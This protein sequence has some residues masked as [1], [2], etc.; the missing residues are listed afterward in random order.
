MEGQ[1]YRLREGLSVRDALHMKSLVGA[2]RHSLGHVAAQ[3]RPR[4][5]APT[6]TS[7]SLL[8]DLNRSRSVSTSSSSSG[9]AITTSRTSLGSPECDAAPA[10]TTTAPTVI[11]LAVSD[12]PVSEGSLPARQS[13]RTSAPS[14][15]VTPQ[16][17]QQI[18]LFLQH[19]TLPP[20]PV[21]HELPTSHVRSIPPPASRLPSRGGN[22]HDMYH[23]GMVPAHH[24]NPVALIPHTLPQTI[25]PHQQP[26]PNGLFCLQ[27]QQ[28]FVVPTLPASHGYSSAGMTRFPGGMSPCFRFPN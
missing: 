13:S 28:N 8:G 2:P 9:N 1:N 21:N 18:Q 19:S 15:V 25:L 26:V 23:R 4:T 11:S 16:Q 27:Q 10:S 6:I 20:V 5:Q 24:Y 14:Y 3:P 12:E 17:L 7:L 22:M